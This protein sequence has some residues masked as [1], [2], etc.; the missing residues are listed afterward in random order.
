MRK[1]AKARAKDIAEHAE[2]QPGIRGVDEAV[3]A[4]LIVTVVAPTIVETTAATT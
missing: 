1:A 2:D 3:E 4:A